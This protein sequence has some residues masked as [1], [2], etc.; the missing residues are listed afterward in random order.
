[1]LHSFSLRSFC[2]SSLVVISAA[3]A[4]CGGKDIPAKTVFT[5][6]EKQQVQELQKQRLDEW[7]KPIK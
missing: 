1:M 3:I 4:G 2:C 7:G 6:Q 5:D